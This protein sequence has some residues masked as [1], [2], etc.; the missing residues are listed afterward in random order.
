MFDIA[1]IGAGISGCSSAYFLTQSGLSVALID[2][3]G[4]AAGGSGAAGAFVSPKF[5]KSGPVK[6]VSEAAFTYAMQFYKEHFSDATKFSELLHLA[7]SELSNDRVKYFKEHTTF[8]QANTNEECFNLLTPYA[9]EF[10]HITLKECALVDSH[11]VCQ[12]L[13]KDATFFKLH[14]NSVRYENGLYDVEGIEAKKVILTTGAHKHLV[15]MPYFTPRAIFGHRINIKTST[16]NPVNIHQFVSI[17]KSIDDDIIA[18][19]ATHDVHYNL[20]ESDVAYDYE[21]GRAELLQRA[22]KS[23]ALKDIEVLEDHIGMRSASIDHLPLVGAVVDAK[24]TV[25]KLPEI[26]R[27]KKYNADEYEYFNN[28]Y[29]INGVG[30]Y[31]FV[32][33]PYLAQ[34]LCDHIVSNEVIDTRLLPS[35]FL[36]RYIK[37]EF[38]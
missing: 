12:G 30:G 4:I 33:G 14:V 34:I 5:V 20:L 18:I 3:S 38:L 29:T 31:G 19:G 9:K 17:S 25:E 35:R 8:T 36:R 11:K 27:G 6:D 22:Q 15:N 7:N 16:H 24:K 21:A 1:I 28:L 26:L 2:E 13:A 23:I 32:L 37:K 10:E